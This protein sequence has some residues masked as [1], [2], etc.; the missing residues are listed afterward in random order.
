MSA[1]M[2]EL[3]RFAAAFLIAGAVAIIFTL[4][5]GGPVHA[6]AVQTANANSCGATG[7]YGYTGFGTIFAG[8]AAGFPAGSASTNGT[9]TFERNGHVTIHEV[10]VV[11]GQVVSPAGGSTFEGT[12]TVNH[13]CTFTATLPP[14]P[15]TAIVG[16]VVDNGKQL[17]AML[18]IPGVQL[19]FVS[20]AQVNP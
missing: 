10:E 15:G 19:N 20:T 7:T 5:Q 18:T 16:V 9:I 13:D 3:I 8:N 17:R 6:V 1:R 12:L 4:L 2:P 11:D 14:L